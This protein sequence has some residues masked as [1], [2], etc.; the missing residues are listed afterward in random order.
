MVSYS[1]RNAVRLWWLALALF[2]GAGAI[3]SMGGR[4]Q[5]QRRASTPLPL[6]VDPASLDFGEVV[7]SSRFL[8]D[9][10]LCNATAEPLTVRL[11]TSCD[12]TGVEPRTLQLAPGETRRVTVQLDLLHNRL[13]FAGRPKRPYKAHL[14]AI[15]GEKPQDQSSLELAGVVKAV[16]SMWPPNLHLKE[17]LVEGEDSAEESVDIKS[18]IPLSWLVVKKCPPSFQIRI[19]AVKGGYTLYVRIKAGLPR[20]RFSET[21]ILKMVDAKGAASRTSRFP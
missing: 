7:E 21:V 10:P 19:Q 20:G 13:H 3:W 18:V 8:H 2:V 1:D 11:E 17:E 12:C 6:Q 16:L 5:P 4:W 14:R 15:F 9:L